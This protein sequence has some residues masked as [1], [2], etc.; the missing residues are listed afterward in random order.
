MPKLLRRWI[1]ALKAFKAVLLRGKDAF[2]EE[3]LAEQNNSESKQSSYFLKNLAQIGYFADGTPL[4]P[5]TFKLWRKL[6][7]AEKIKRN[8][9]CLNQRL[10]R[11]ESLV[12][13]PLKLNPG[14]HYHVFLHIPKAGGTTLEH[15]IAK[16]YLPNQSIH[17]NAPAIAQNPSM[18]F[19]PDLQ[20][21]RGVLMG[22]YQRS[23]VLYQ[24]LGDRSIIHFTM[25]REPIQRVISH[26]NYIKT[27]SNHPLNERARDWVLEEYA[28]SDIKEVQNNQT[29]RILGDCG[30]EMSKRSLEDPELLL[31]EAKEVLANEFSLFGLTERYSEFL[32]MASKLLGWQDIFYIRKNSSKRSPRSA[33]VIES[34]QFREEALQ[35]IHERNQLDIQLYAYAQELFEQRW[36]QLGLGQ[37]SVEK[38]DLLNANYKAMLEEVDTF[39]Q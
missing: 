17:A 23:S 19:H 4:N 21:P 16:N 5:E 1:D 25:L 22:H 6:S 37:A 11:W 34:N 3:H 26:F 8:A 36:Q 38:Y 24:F 39:F 20:H 13:T 27:R 15:I 10:V 30:G 33:K 18:I 29:L 7:T 31:A 32:I 9:D 14:G 12:T 28:Q 2:L 35:L